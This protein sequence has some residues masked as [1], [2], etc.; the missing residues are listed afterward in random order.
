MGLLSILIMVVV[1]AVLSL[2]LVLLKQ[3][4]DVKAR[5]HLFFLVE[6]ARESDIFVRFYAGQD[7]ID[8]LKTY[9]RLLSSTDVYG[10]SLLTIAL[11]YSL[12]MLALYLIEQGL[13]VNKPDVVGLRPLSRAILLWNPELI[14]AMLKAG[15]HVNAFDAFHETS[16]FLYAIDLLGDWKHPRG[17]DFR[18]RCE[19]IKMLVEA[20]A[21]IHTGNPRG[22]ALEKGVHEIAEYL[23]AKGAT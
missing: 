16:P 1:L 14:R 4:R 23:S 19:I 11:N 22:I 13:D 9:P 12:G 17:E 2:L 6:Q 10:N 7:V 18:Q 3:K 8:Y 15:A 20:G 5:K 21:D